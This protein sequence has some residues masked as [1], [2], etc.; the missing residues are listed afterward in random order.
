LNYNRIEALVD[1][2]NFASKRALLKNGFELEGVLRDYEFEYGHY[3][4]LE[5]YSIIKRTFNR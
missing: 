3:V 4:D 1:V 5:M 2:N